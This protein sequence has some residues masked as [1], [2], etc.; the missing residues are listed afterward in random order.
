MHKVLV[1]LGKRPNIHIPKYG[2]FNKKRGY[3]QGIRV[4]LKNR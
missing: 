1:S 3:Q 2:P 4:P